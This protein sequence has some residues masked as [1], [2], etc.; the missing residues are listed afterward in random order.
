[1]DGGYFGNEGALM[2]FKED[3]EGWEKWVFGEERDENGGNGDS[4]P[5]LLLVRCGARHR[6]YGARHKANSWALWFWILLLGLLAPLSSG[7]SE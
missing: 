1:M 4:A 2:G 3:L 7:G 6:A 5:Y